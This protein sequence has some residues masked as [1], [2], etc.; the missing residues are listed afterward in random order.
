M[1]QRTRM[2]TNRW[3]ISECSH[4]VQ[5]INR[6][7]STWSNTSIEFILRFIASTFRSSQAK[8]FR[9]SNPNP[10]KQNI[11]T[12]NSIFFLSFFDNE[13]KREVYLHKQ[14]DIPY[15][16]TWASPVCVNIQSHLCFVQPFLSPDPT[17]RG[18][19]F[20]GT[21]LL[22][23]K[24]LPPPIF[25]IILTARSR[26]SSLLC[27][28]IFHSRTRK[29]GKKSR[30]ME[31][32]CLFRRQRQVGTRKEVSR[33][34]NWKPQ[35]IMHIINIQMSLPVRGPSASSEKDRTWCWKMKLTSFCW[36]IERE[37]WEM[38]QKIIYLVYILLPW[39]TPLFLFWRVNVWILIRWFEVHFWVVI[40]LG[41]GFRPPC[42]A[43]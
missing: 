9:T 21:K 33:K 30:Q 38:K 23:K 27:L 16:V 6:T 43:W 17:L 36:S 37:L 5:D 32:E 35:R 28:P 3:S 14:I 15:H 12:E 42:L 22:M 8:T 19:I 1:S 4:A 29:K 39:G 2:M 24:L 25:D 13:P 40:W 10:V 41:L 11:D 18:V 20:L 31:I 7:P 26:G 34:E